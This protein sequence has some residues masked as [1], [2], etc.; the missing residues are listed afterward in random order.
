MN[1]RL[2]AGHERAIADWLAPGLAA[3]A[4][5]AEDEVL[6]WGPRD[7]AIHVRVGD[8]L[9][10]HHPAY[11]PLP[12]S[13]YRAALR[14]VALSLPPEESHDAAGGGNTPDAEHAARHRQHTRADLSSELASAE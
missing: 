10:G 2:F 11:R 8:I 3:A 13:F 7:V 12:M 5:A 6:S 4:G 14:A 9:W 1:T